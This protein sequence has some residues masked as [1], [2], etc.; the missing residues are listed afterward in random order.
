MYKDDTKPSQLY[1][2]EFTKK[3]TWVRKFLVRPKREE[4][5]S[6]VLR[7]TNDTILFIK[8]YEMEQMNQ[9]RL[10][11]INIGISVGY[12]LGRFVFSAEMTL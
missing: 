10:Q 11:T 7:D 5:R 8:Q 3:T 2:P 9:I 1:F 12:F 4:L 6:Y